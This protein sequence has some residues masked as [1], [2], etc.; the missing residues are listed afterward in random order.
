MK[1]VEV[2]I[3]DNLLYDTLA[4]EHLLTLFFQKKFITA[5][6]L[7]RERVT[8]EVQ[9]YNSHLT[10][11]FQGLVAPTD[12]ERVL[13]GNRIPKKHTI[14]LEKQCQI[15]LEAF[16]RNGFILLVDNQQVSELD[17]KIEIHSGTQVI[18]LKLTPLVGG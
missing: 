16:E 17:E 7:I 4:E 1:D 10:D 6:E 15:A 9:S 5:R 8:Q 2:V 3:H 14:D 11:I 12:A 13:N 18:F